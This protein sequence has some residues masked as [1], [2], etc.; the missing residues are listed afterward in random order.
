MKK[1]F[2]GNTRLF[3]CISG[4]IIAVAHITCL[5]HRFDMLDEQT[6]AQQPADSEPSFTQKTPS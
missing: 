3:L 6:H 2:T 5:K 4:A 1:T